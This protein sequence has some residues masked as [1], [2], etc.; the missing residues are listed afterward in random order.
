ME[1]LIE[2]SNKIKVFQN[3]IQVISLVNEVTSIQFLEDKMIIKDIDTSHICLFELVLDSQWFDDY[4]IKVKQTL[5]INL[6]NF[7]K[8][9]SC[10]QEG[11]RLLL[12]SKASSD[13]LS[14]DFLD[15]DSSKKKPVM[16]F[17]INLIDR[18]FDPINSNLDYNGADNLLMQSSQFE[19]LVNLV[20]SFGDAISIRYAD[21]SFTYSSEGNFNETKIKNAILDL[22]SVDDYTNDDEI[23]L[24]FSINYLSKI[25]KAS[26]ISVDLMLYF[27]NK[28]PVCLKYMIGSDCHLTY[29]L[30]PKIEDDED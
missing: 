6:K 17:E 28:Y 27:K 8:V 22:D 20:G 3:A 9:L 23:E 14:I 24:S 7:V 4:R 16:Q 29:W 18:D 10:L 1:I 12:S 25:V 26:K 19:S 11:Q 21:D 15:K 30:P 13:Q 5:G 2:N